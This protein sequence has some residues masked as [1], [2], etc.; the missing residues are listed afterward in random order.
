MHEKLCVS[1]GGIQLKHFRE[2][3]LQ[4]EARLV[5]LRLDTLPQLQEEMGAVRSLV[6]SLS[7]QMDVIITV[8]SKNEK[9][10]FEGSEANRVAVLKELVSSC[11]K[12]ID[13]ELE[14]PSAKEVT[15]IC[16]EIGVKTIV[17]KHDFS[18][19]PDLRRLTGYVEKAVDFGASVVKVVT[20]ARSSED[21]LTML[22]LDSIFQG[23]TVGFCMGE[24][25][26]P[27]R[28]LAP[29]FG[30]PFTYASFGKES[31]APGQLSAKDVMKIWSM[32]GLLQ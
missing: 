3:A 18:Q 6:Q 32:M 22:K 31:L 21:N 20:Y 24:I 17:S 2:K 1:I 8:K 23:S 19:T 5:E 29:F 16:S 27:S 10:F 30:S 13:I 26:V 7:S 9:G 25:G 15:K 4:S 14:S 28:I 11:P 12:Y